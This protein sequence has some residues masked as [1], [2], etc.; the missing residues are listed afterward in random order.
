VSSTDHLAPRYAISSIRP[1]PRPSSVQIF[2]STPCSQTPSVSFP[3]AISTTKFHTHTNHYHTSLN[4]S[5]Y[6]L[7]GQSSSKGS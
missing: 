7:S 3:P 2:T 1:L 6:A 4:T 5:R